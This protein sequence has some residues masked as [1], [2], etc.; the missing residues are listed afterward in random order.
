MHAVHVPE[1]RHAEADQ[2]RALP[3]PIPIHERGLRRI[4]DRGVGAA[5]VVSRALERLEGLSDPAAFLFPVGDRATQ[6]SRSLEQVAADRRVVGQL[7]LVDGHAV[8]RELERLVDADAPVLVGLPHHPRD[9]VDVDL[10]EAELPRVLEDAVDLRRAMGTSVDLE[11]AVVEVLDAETE[12]GNAE[13]TDRGQFALAERP[14]LAFERDL[15]GAAPVGSRRQAPHQALQLR[16]RQERGGAAPEIH[17]MHRA[18]ANGRRVQ[19]HLPLARH[20]AQVVL[21]LPRVLVGVDPEI[22][23][24]T[25]LPAERDVQVEAERDGAGPCIQRAVSLFQRRRGPHRE[26]RIVRDEIAANGGFVAIP[27]V[28]RFR[29]M[30]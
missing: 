6:L 29:H 30:A 1:R 17:E 24:V 15:G 21:D 23:E 16:G 7:H 10:R 25:A 26:R 28:R 9:Q 11:N 12:A 20:Q 5:D 14:R 22:A 19:V 4:L 27:R 2:V 13:L 8:G 18:A 3:Q